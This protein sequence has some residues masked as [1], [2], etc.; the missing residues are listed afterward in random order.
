MRASSFAT[1]SVISSLVALS[2]AAQDDSD[3]L[4]LKLT[5]VMAPFSEGAEVYR[6]IQTGVLSE[7]NDSRFF[8][9]AVSAD[10]CY[11]FVATSEDTL[12]DLDMF[13]YAD[14]VQLTENTANDNFPVIQ[15]CNTV[16]DRVSVE[17]RAYSGQGRYAFEVLAYPRMPDG[18]DETLWAALNAVT[19]RYAEGARPARAPWMDVLP[20]RSDRLFAVNLVP[21]R[22]YVVVAVGGPTVSDLDLVLIDGVGDE[23]DADFRPDAIAVLRYTVP[24]DSS[25]RYQIRLVMAAGF[26]EYAVQ[27]LNV[28]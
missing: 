3:A 4:I 19:G 20:E 17:L 8:E 15:W 13:V 23:V 11:S 6:P 7:S 16:F 25:G 24:T 21:G 14:N 2:A 18:F 10:Q 28:D 12:D 22:T 27:L 9:I 26:G 5:D 1:I